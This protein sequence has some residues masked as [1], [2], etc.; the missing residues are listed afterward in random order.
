MRSAST[1]PSMEGMRRA[2]PCRELAGGVGASEIVGNARSSVGDERGG[3][4]SGDGEIIGPQKF[5]GDRLE[6]LRRL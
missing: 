5:V 6:R 2:G 1:E 3:A 4:V